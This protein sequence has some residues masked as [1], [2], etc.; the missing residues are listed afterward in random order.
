MKFDSIIFLLDRQMAVFR[1]GKLFHL[2]GQ[3]P[4]KQDADG[5][6]RISLER[7]PQIPLIPSYCHLEED[8]E[9][10][11]EVLTGI[12]PYV[13]GFFRKQS[14]LLC[15]PD[16]A[17]VYVEQKYIRDF[18]IRKGAGTNTTVRTVESLCLARGREYVAVSRSE[19]L[20]TMTYRKG[21]NQPKSAHLPLSLANAGS[22]RMGIRNLSPEIEY[23][24]PDTYILDPEGRLK[25]YHE[26]GRVL[27]L[28]ELAGFAQ[29]LSEQNW[30]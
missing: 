1:P 16:D 20:L 24:Q 12:R 26:L 23:N 11:R 2:P 30:L 4:E 28:K 18:F 15:V 9:A 6:C 25:E 7:L 19:R 13:K 10:S 14:I 29:E 5:F 17:P 8:S 22:V 21:Q 3:A 27:G